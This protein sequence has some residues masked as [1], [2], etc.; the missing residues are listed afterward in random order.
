MKTYAG[1]WDWRD[2]DVVKVVLGG[3]FVKF[4]IA[5]GKITKELMELSYPD[6]VSKSCEVPILVKLHP[7]DQ[8]CHIVSEA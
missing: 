3:K 1:L 2:A 6:G 8:F 4:Q 5:T 7:D